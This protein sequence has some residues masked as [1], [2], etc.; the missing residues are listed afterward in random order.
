MS[1]CPF[2]A[3]CA[4]P[5]LNRLQAGVSGAL[6]VR[7]D[8]E[9]GQVTGRIYWQY[10]A[11]YGLLSFLVLIVLW[12]SEQVGHDGQDCNVLNWCAWAAS[13][14]LAACVSAGC[15]CLVYTSGLFHHCPH[16]PTPAPH[17]T[18]NPQAMRI[19]TSWYL[20]R[21]SGAELVAQLTGRPVDRIRYIGGYLGFALGGPA[22]AGCTGASCLAYTRCL[23][24]LNR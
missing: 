1:L 2:P 19:L 3:A 20:T 17:L 18:H 21:W 4:P 13:D 6:I 24:T 11:A 15:V 7:E 8:Q 14:V 16:P 12:S 5:R 22:L 10:I 23:P 9:V